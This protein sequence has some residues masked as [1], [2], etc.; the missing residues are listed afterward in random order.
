MAGNEAVTDRSTLICFIRLIG[1]PLTKE[2]GDRELAAAVHFLKVHLDALP[3]EKKATGENEEAQRLMQEAR[4]RID[5]A[6]KT[7]GQ[8]L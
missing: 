5:D 6:E 4:R 2:P 1:L 7:L 3:R 8:K